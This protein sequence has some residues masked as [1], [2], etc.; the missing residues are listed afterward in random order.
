MEVVCTQALERG[1]WWQD[2]EGAAAAYAESGQQGQGLSW[3]QQC[4]TPDPSYLPPLLGE[5]FVYLW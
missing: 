4:R 5:S 1:R 2:L 3:P